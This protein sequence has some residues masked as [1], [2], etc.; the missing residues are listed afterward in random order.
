MAGDDRRLIRQKVTSP[1][2]LITA[3]PA[4]RAE[5]LR[6]KLG[7]QTQQPTA[8]RKAGVKQFYLYNA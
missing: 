4:R 8:A 1:E 6:Y 5:N 2:A 3:S 7:D